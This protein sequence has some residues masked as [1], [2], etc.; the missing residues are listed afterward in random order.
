MSYPRL[1]LGVVSSLHSH[2]SLS[3]LLNS[4]SRMIHVL[5]SP[6]LEF[7]FTLLGDSEESIRTVCSLSMLSF[8]S[9]QYGVHSQV[10]YWE[11]KAYLY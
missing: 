4:V 11:N 8:A 10:L 9:V 3:A 6:H 2:L 7:S 1:F 5:S